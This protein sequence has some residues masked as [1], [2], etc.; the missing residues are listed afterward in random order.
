MRLPLLEN[1]KVKAFA[2]IAL[3][4]FLAVGVLLI[5]PVVF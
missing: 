2:V 4:T 1:E 5:L 3:L